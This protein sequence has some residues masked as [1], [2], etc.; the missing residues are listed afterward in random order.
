ML[1]EQTLRRAGGDARLLGLVWQLLGLILRGAG[2]TQG[3][4]RSRG[5]PRLAATRPATVA[6]TRV[7]AYARELLR[8]FFEERQID[9]AATRLGLARRRF[10]TLFRDAAG[11]HLVH[12]GAGPAAGAH[13]PV[14]ARNGAV[15]DVDLRRVRLRR[16]L[17]FLP[18]LPGGRTVEPAAWRGKKRRSGT[19]VAVRRPGPFHTSEGRALDP[20]AFDAFHLGQAGLALLQAAHE[21]IDRVNA[22]LLDVLLHPLNA[23]RMDG[24]AD[25]A[26]VAVPTCGEPRTLF[27]M[28]RNQ[29]RAAGET[30]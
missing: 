13:A 24:G 2:A 3:A 28:Q 10:T 21:H 12:Y 11:K 30:V 6:K 17:Q 23:L 9:V 26:Q 15:G 16:R 14:A 18:C 1:H 19:R 20:I 29:P 4:V 8:T 22:H 5:G 7:A 27:G 25:L